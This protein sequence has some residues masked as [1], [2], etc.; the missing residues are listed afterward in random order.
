MSYDYEY[1]RGRYNRGNYGN[2][3]DEEFDNRAERGEGGSYGDR[4]RGYNDSYQQNPY[5]RSAGYGSSSNEPYRSRYYENYSNEPYGS[6]DSG[7]YIYGD[8]SG[9]YGNRYGGNSGDRSWQ[10]YGTEGRY[11]E[12]YSRR[13]PNRNYQDRGIWERAGDEVRSWF[14]DE[15]AERRRQMDQRRSGQHAGRGPK[16]YRRS[17]ERIREDVNERLTDDP[18]LDASNIEVTVDATIVTLTGTVEDRRDKRRAESLAEMVAGVTDISNQL[19]VTPSN[20]TENTT[21]PGTA[22]SRAART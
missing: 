21:M 12:P 22:R 7:R 14:G 20:Q 1:Q 16:G 5:D 6:Y 17:D 4:Y 19:R 10:G 15:E 8:S 13:L 18:Y 9:E 11:N 3:Y 2:R